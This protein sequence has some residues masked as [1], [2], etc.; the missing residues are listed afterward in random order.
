MYQ[1]IILIGNLGNDPELRSTASGQ[2][3]GSFRLAVNK[4]WTTAEG[5][6]REKTTWFRV[7]FWGKIAE[8][9]HQN[10]VKGSQVMVIGEV[11]DATVYT[12]R[13]GEPAA[14]LEVTGRVIKFLNN[15]GAHAGDGVAIDEM[16]DAHRATARQQGRR[17]LSEENIPF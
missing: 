17:Q 15:W 8:L 6:M 9:V 5:E 1:Q 3:V 13:A 12:N 2:S 10:L 14:S 7:S 16:T 4:R 11:E